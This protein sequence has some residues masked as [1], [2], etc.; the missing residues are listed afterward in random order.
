MLPIPLL[1]LSL[2]MLIIKHLKN[3]KLLPMNLVLFQENLL[4]LKL[5]L[6]VILKFMQRNLIDYEKEDISFKNKANASFWKNVRFENSQTYFRVEEY[7]RPKF[8]S[9]F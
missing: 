3:L 9:R 8:E 2:E 5:D 1:K 7:K 4:C 6:Q